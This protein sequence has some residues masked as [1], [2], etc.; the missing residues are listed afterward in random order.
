MYAGV[1]P[2]NVDCFRTRV[3]GKIR[4]VEPMGFHLRV[5]PVGGVL[6]QILSTFNVDVARVVV[7]SLE[8]GGS[9]MILVPISRDKGDFLS[10]QD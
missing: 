2:W 4:C 1:V 9:T 5:S 7:F 3:E 10:T 8:N 6:F